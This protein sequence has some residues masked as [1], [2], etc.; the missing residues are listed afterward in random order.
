M[1]KVWYA[2]HRFEM[3]GEEEI[4]AVEKC[5]RDG[6]L[7]G[8]GPQTESFEKIVAE[9]FGKKNGLFVNSGSSANLVALASLN[10]PA[11]SCIVTPACTFATTVAPIIQLGH[12]PVFCDVGLTQYVPSVEQVMEKVDKN[13]RVVLLPN[14][15]GNVPNWLG[16]R[17]ALHEMGRDDVILFEDSADT[18]TLGKHSDVSTT[19]FY[20]SHIITAGGT[21]GMAMFNDNAH[22]ARATMYR[23]W[24]RVGNNVEDMSSRFG[25]SIDG[26][27]YD[28]KFTYAVMGYNLKCSEMNAAFGIVQMSRLEDNIQRRRRNFLRY[29]HN[30]KTCSHIV[31]PD[32][33]RSPN[34]LAM[35]LQYT[36]NRMKLLQYLEDN[37]VQTRVTFSGNITR[38][39]AFKQYQGA[40]SNSDDIMRRGFLVGCHHGMSEGD[41]DYVCDKIISFCA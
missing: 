24:G 21:G 31:L 6:W 13:T 14:L 41:V 28:F 38:H 4:K 35:P 1:K 27:P 8:T 3:Y 17:Q 20:S 19:S 18:I 39:D 37:Q 22:L 34:W 36:G 23:D 32:D 16:L 26:I 5:L 11:G 2:P 33:E 10:L 7:A 9:R 25:H 30:L 15:I 12:V 40:F 29:I